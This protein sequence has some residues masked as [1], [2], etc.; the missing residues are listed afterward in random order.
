MARFNLSA[1]VCHRLI[2]WRGQIA[3]LSGE[4]AL[5]A[6]MWG[7]ALAYRYLDRRPDCLKND[8][9]QVVRRV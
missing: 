5:T 8:S 2:V 1:R 7:K 4:V 6:R 3:D 9:I